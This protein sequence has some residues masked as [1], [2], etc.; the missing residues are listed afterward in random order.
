MIADKAEQTSLQSLGRKRLEKNKNLPI[1]ALGAW[2]KRKN[3]RLPGNFLF[4]A[5][6]HK[7]C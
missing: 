3:Q 2:R 6:H 4:P 7:K 1:K 5:L